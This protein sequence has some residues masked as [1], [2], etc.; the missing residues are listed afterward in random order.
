MG[1]LARDP[2]RALASGPPPTRR[3]QSG[4]PAQPAPER[5]LASGVLGLVLV[6]ATLAPEGLA[7]N[8][9]RLAGLT[10]P[11]GGVDLRRRRSVDTGHPH[12]P[13]C[14]KKPTANYADSRQ[15]HEMVIIS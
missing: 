8:P 14:G 10:E 13:E 9:E 12:R 2:L 1:P 5:T 6:A 3:R 7:G 15:F 4:C 11:V